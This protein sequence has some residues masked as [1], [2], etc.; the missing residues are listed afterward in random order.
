MI[1]QTTQDDNHVNQDKNH[2]RKIYEH[3]WVIKNFPKRK[4]LE[5]DK[6]TVEVYLSLK[7]L[8]WLLLKLYQKN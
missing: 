8:I 2:D 4:I 1:P 3:Q 6:I 7:E 5:P